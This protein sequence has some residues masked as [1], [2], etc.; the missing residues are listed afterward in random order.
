MH[1][2]RVIIILQFIIANL[3]CRASDRRR[4]LI[5]I[6]DDRRNYDDLTNMKYRN[7]IHTIILINECTIILTEISYKKLY[8]RNT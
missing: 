3:K 1:V 5:K 4:A 6:H 2:D 7:K 8:G